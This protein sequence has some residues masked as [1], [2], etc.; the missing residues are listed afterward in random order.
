MQRAQLAAI[1]AR[2]RGFLGPEYDGSGLEK[3]RDLVRQTM[4]TFPE[5]Q[6]S[7]EKLYQTLDHINEAQAEK[8]FT[9]GMYYKR[10]GKVASAEYYL[11]KIP[12]RWPNS[13]WAAKAKIEL[14][15]LAKMP[16]KPSKPS[17]IIIPPGSTDPFMSAGPMGGVPG[18][19]MGG[20]GMGMPGMGMGGMG[21]PGGMM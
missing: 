9:D 8:S 21:M 2:M 7:Y 14:A 12:Q 18:M 1:D 10:I 5:R 15:S 3:A 19:G 16:R 4:R 11:G 6:A 17:K 20:M 13:A